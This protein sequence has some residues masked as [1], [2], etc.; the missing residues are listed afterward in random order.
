L[1]FVMVAPG[2][3]VARCDLVADCDVALDGHALPSSVTASPARSGRS[4]TA[5]LSCGRASSRSSELAVAVVGL[6]RIHAAD[7]RA[8]HVAFG[9]TTSSVLTIASSAMACGMITTPSRSPSR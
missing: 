7:Q 1:Y 5:T 4:A 6:D 8:P 9:A 2:G 3:D